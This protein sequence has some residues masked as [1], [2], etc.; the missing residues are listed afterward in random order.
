VNA[1]GTLI[2]GPA[3]GA[4]KGRVTVPGDKSMSH[5]AVMLASLADGT[6][7]IHGFL[8][9]ED[10]LATARMFVDMGVTIEWLNS[11]RTSLRVHGVGLR[12]LKRPSMMLDAGNSGTCVRLMTGVLAGQPFTTTMTGD[13][14]LCKRPMKRVVDP[15]RRMGAVIDGGDG[16]NLLPIT[17][18]GGALKA[19]H[20]VSEVA[21]AQVKSCL[22]LAGL[23]ADGE[24]TLVEPRPT[25]DHTER[26]LPLFGQPVHVDDEGM[27]HLNPTGKLTAPEEPI[28]I[29]ADPSS[30]SFF[31]VAA[32]LIPGSDI[33]LERIG[34]NPLRNGWSRILSDMN[35]QMEL[36]NEGVVGEEAVADI[37]VTYQQLAGIDVNPVDV[38]DSIDEF[39]V[40]FA[41]AS[42]ADGEFVLSEAEELRVK[43]SDRI[44]VMARALMAAGADV[45]ERP[46]GVRI[47]GG[48][49]KGDCRVDAE[50][51]HRIAMAMAVAAQCAGAE[52]AVENAAAI[53]TSFPD[54]VALAQELGMNVRWDDG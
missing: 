44:A 23:F 38:P 48:A 45:E 50:G 34:M 39:P 30:A 10:N 36:Q 19:I 9:G 20:Y 1:G 11:E 28:H 46:D 6:T 41:A 12:G 14:S 24:T 47:K 53:A 15:V 7:E 42:L 16:G 17:I 29:P 8:P 27:I 54:F 49:L 31:A 32:S 22:L 5:R 33:T 18:K 3:A 13:A 43:E 25:R 26:M 35:G 4:L 52:I 37:H 2:A 40:L 51:D 21:S